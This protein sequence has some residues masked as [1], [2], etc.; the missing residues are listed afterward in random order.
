MKPDMRLQL[1]H[2][3][4]LAVLLCAG[5]M[6]ALATQA[7]DTKTVSTSTT[8]N[9]D[10]TTTTT[11]VTTTTT[12]T[13]A[14]DAAASVAGPKLQVRPAGR[15]LLDGAAY[16]SNEKELF[17]A[18]VAIP[19]VRLGARASY[20]KWNALV[21]LGFAYGKISMKDIYIQHNFND[22]NLLRVGY[23]IHQFG[24]QSATSSS[25]KISM[26]EPMVQSAIGNP[27]LFGLMY[28]YDNAPFFATASLYAESKALTFNSTQMRKTGYGGISRLAWRP[29]RG[30]AG[31]QGN[32]AQAGISF[33]AGSPQF[34]GDPDE[35]DNH[36]YSV[37]SCF[38]TQVAQVQAV[39][40]QVHDV[41]SMFKFTPEILAAHG[42][43]AVEAQ[44]YYMQLHRRLD[45]PAYRAWG[46]YGM[47][48]CLATGGDYRYSHG[49]AA[50][51]TP[52]PKSLEFVLGYNYVNTTDSKA[53]IRGGRASDLSLTAN[54]YINKYIIWRL[55]AAYTYRFDR[56]GEPDINLGAL[57]TRFQILF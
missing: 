2:L 23:F 17:P 38:P 39:G 1:R 54:W 34:N 15:A 14:A 57:Q 27:R 36:V 20:G 25:M 18:G 29:L 56:A 12:T 37:V 7:E 47:L 41:N 30:E 9:A 11:V 42:P 21:D 24:L 46:A 35:P 5:S 16:T 3:F 53:S 10:G 43:L 48:R 52:A 32:I 31:G 45:L 40:A 22:C 4:A 6:P 44:Y 55:R 51:A 8:T 49:D 19:D 33:Q 28:V 50:L 13:A 26:E